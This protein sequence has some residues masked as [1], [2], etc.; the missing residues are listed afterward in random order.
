MMFINAMY[1]SFRPPLSAV[2]S[3]SVSRPF[4]CTSPLS[5]F[6]ATKLEYSSAVQVARSSKALPSSEVHRIVHVVAVERRLQDA[7]GE[8]DIVHRRTVVGV[9]RRWSH[10]PVFAVGRL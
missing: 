9:H 7:G 8:V 1:A 5:S 10:G 3:P 2:F 6:T 4:R